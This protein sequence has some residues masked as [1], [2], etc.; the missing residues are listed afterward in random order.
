M[1][2]P[3]K[4]GTPQP[5]VDCEIYLDDFTITADDLPSC[6][7]QTFEVIRRLVTAGAMVNLGKSVIGSQE[8]KVLGH[9][10]HGGGY[11][12]AEG[13]GLKAL[14]SVGHEAMKKIPVHSVYGLLSFFRP[15]V[16]DFATRTEPLRRLLASSHS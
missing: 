7:D 2:G 1:H 8:G 14:L 6:L 13:K 12:T 15:Y 4:D 5:P 16:A 3:N 11:F 10:W 9:R